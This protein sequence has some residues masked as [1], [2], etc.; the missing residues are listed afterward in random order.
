L[1][2]KQRGDLNESRIGH[3][4]S[5]YNE[6]D[7]FLDCMGPVNLSASSQWGFFNAVISASHNPNPG[8]F[9]EVVLRPVIVHDKAWITTGCI[10]YD[11]EIGEGAIVSVGSVVRSRIVPPWT[12]VEGNPAMIVA[13]YNREEKRW[14]YQDPEPLERFHHAK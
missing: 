13:R 11:C 4:A 7:T 3:P 1:K 2:S 5:Y 9:G 14:A 8:H 12:I 10:L 6:R